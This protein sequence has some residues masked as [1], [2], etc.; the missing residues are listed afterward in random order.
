MKTANIIGLLIIITLLV[1]IAFIKKPKVVG[2][3]V[4][5]YT[6]DTI[7]VPVPY[8]V[9]VPY[10]KEVPPKI[11]Y[12]Y[13]SGFD[14]IT[15]DSLLWRISEN[16]LLIEYMSQSLSYNERFLVSYPLNPKLLSFDLNRDSMN[17]S[18]L[19]PDGDLFSYNYPIDLNNFKYRWVDHQLTR[20]N[21]IL[22]VTK[23]KEVSLYGNVGYDFVGLSPIIGLYIDKP[24][25]K[26]RAYSSADIGLLNVKASSLKVGIGYKINL[27]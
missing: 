22:P 11:V 21:D 20:K 23:N 12:Q 4:P 18:L 14:S 8:E 17:L 6:T 19:N 1:Y 5:T 25:G 7:Q 9:P 2:V 13:Y 16:E 15:L 24:F 27:K 10:P 26:F 3:P